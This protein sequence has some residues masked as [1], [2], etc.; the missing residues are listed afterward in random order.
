MKESTIEKI[1]KAGMSWIGTPYFHMANVK[2][3][4]ADCALFL[5]SLFLEAGIISKVETLNYSRNWMVTGQQELM[6][7]GFER[8]LS[9]YINKDFS[10]KKINAPFDLFEFGDILCLTTPGSLVCHHAAMWFGKDLV[11][12]AY[13]RKGVCISQY[14][15]IWNNRLRCVIRVIEEENV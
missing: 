6:I 14:R 12:H 1:K 15:P 9:K 2:G 11:L 5:A 10:Y 8:H 4:G 13:Q 3:A 7:E